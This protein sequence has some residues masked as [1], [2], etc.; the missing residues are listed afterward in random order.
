MAEAEDAIRTI[1]SAEKFV[2]SGTTPFAE[3][4]RAL[5]TSTGMIVTPPEGTGTKKK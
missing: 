5:L 4:A 3:V 2:T 1:E